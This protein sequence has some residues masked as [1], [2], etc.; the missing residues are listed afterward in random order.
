MWTNED[1]WKWGKRLEGDLERIAYGPEATALAEKA[2][3]DV[4]RRMFRLKEISEEVENAE[5]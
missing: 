3:Y 2:D 1:V 5:N 4:V